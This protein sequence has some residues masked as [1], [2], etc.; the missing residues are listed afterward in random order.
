MQFT[1]F[2]SFLRE[3]I[4]IPMTVEMLDPPTR[5]YPVERERKI[6]GFEGEVPRKKRSILEAVFVIH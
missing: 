3:A 4:A 1:H 2:L 5:W 6:S